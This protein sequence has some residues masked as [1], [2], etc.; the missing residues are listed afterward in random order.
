[1][2]NFD[3]LK[4]FA[5]L[6]SAKRNVLGWIPKEVAFTL[7]VSRSAI[8]NWEEGDRLPEEE[9]LPEIAVVYGIG[10]K[11][12]EEA[13]RKTKEAKRSMSRAKISVKDTTT[14]RGPNECGMSVRLGRPARKVKSLGISK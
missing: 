7:G 1:M 10:L 3:D 9:R 4:A 14:L 6:I 13:Y 11:V 2:I 8:S 12:L 5:N